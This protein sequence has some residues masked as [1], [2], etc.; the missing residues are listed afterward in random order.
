[1]QPVQ[2]QIDNLSFQSFCSKI[3]LQVGRG[4]RRIWIDGGIHAR[5]KIKRKFL[6]TFTFRQGVDF[7]SFR[8]F[9]TSL[10]SGGEP[11]LLR[12]TQHLHLLHQP[13]VPTYDTLTKGAQLNINIFPASILMDMSTAE[14][15]IECG[16]KWDEQHKQFKQ[17]EHKSSGVPKTDYLLKS[18]YHRLEADTVA[19]VLVW[20]QTGTGVTTGGERFTMI[21]VMLIITIS[22]AP[23]TLRLTQ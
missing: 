8:V 19:V 1:M 22:L 17:H 13:Q 2:T 6:T 14:T 10:P 12:H 16:E 18:L 7:P 9:H 23:I 11:P 20:I 15:T 3:S 4:H 5:F 21:N